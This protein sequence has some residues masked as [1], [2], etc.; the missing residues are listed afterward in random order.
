MRMKRR[1]KITTAMLARLPLEFQT[2]DRMQKMTIHVAT[3][4]IAKRCLPGVTAADADKAAAAEAQ[5]VQQTRQQT[6]TEQTPTEKDSLTED[7][8]Y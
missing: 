1:C 4:S 5:K 3:I 7:A 2:K 6:R 8:K